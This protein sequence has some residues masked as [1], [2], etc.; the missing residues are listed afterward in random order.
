[1][2]LP[3]VISRATLN[4]AKVLGEENMIGTLAPGSRADI[5]FLEPVEGRWVLSDAEG[6]V[7]TVDERFV[8]AR[9]FCAGVDI[10]P[11][12]RLLRDIWEW[13]N[14]LAAE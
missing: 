3:D 1:M 11:S 9:V 5:T 6:E 10:E 7:L 8:P 2:A 12:K 13:E 14:T 4:P